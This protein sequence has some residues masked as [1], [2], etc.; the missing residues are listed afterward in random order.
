MQVSTYPMVK[1]SEGRRHIQ[2]RNAREYCN[3]MTEGVH[4]VI[5]FSLSVCMPVSLF[6]CVS[7]YLSVRLLVSLS[8][9]LSVE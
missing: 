8:M 7:S 5:L 3:V 9:C 6:A 4:A 2:D 1:R